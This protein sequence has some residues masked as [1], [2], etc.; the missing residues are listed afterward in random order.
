MQ[1]SSGRRTSESSSL[2]NWA[3]RGRPPASRPWNRP[4]VAVLGVFS[5]SVQTQT[6]LDAPGGSEPET[7]A[8]P[9]EIDRRPLPRTLNPATLHRSQFQCTLRVPIWG[10]QRVAL[11]I[12]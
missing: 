3:G 9:P 6:V 5:S 11:T 7:N 8:L 2:S 4:R 1:R 10:G 12:P